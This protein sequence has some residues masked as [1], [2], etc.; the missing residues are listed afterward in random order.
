M[1]SKPC[2]TF[3]FSF[4]GDGSD[5]TISIDLATGPVFY[6]APASAPTQTALSQLVAGLPSAVGP[7]FYV[8]GP[9]PVTVTATYVALTGLL[10]ITLSDDPQANGVYYVRGTALY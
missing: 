6:S 8:D 2:I 5:R 4:V 3:Q 9:T 10:T 7:T 1:A